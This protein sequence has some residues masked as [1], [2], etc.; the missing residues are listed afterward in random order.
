M[1]FRHLILA[2]A[3]CGC[4]TAC[5]PKPPAPD[6]TPISTP[7]STPVVTDSPTM[8]VTISP[9]K[10]TYRVPTGEL[11]TFYAVTSNGKSQEFTSTE[12]VYTSDEY[13][14]NVDQKALPA[15]TGNDFRTMP[16]N[17]YALRTFLLGE[18]NIDIINTNI[19]SSDEAVFEIKEVIDEYEYAGRMGVSLINR[20]QLFVYKVLWDPQALSEDSQHQLAK[21]VSD[22]FNRRVFEAGSTDTTVENPNEGISRVYIPLANT[23]YDIVVPGSAYI[24]NIDG[25]KNQYDIWYGK[26]IAASIQ[27]F[28]TSQ[29]DLSITEHNLSLVDYQKALIPTSGNYENFKITTAPTAFV[30]VDNGFSNKVSYVWGGEAKTYVDLY[31]FA[32]NAGFTVITVKSFE[33]IP[34]SFTTDYMKFILDSDRK[35]NGELNTIPQAL[36]ST[37]VPQD[38]V[39]PLH[40]ESSAFKHLRSVSEDF[41]ES[42]FGETN[43]SGAFM[44]KQLYYKDI[45]QNVLLPFTASMDA[46]EGSVESASSAWVPFNGELEDAKQV[47]ITYNLF[48]AD[49]TSTEKKEGKVPTDS[50]T[51]GF[52]EAVK[53]IAG[54]FFLEMEEN[55]VYP[56]PDS[57]NVNAS[58]YQRQ[59]SY[60]CN[61]T[62][63]NKSYT[64]N[65]AIFIKN[66]GDDKYQDKSRNY[67]SA[68]MVWGSRAPSDQV[69]NFQQAFES[70]VK[71]VQ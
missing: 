66:M 65:V 6:S 57:E 17:A 40:L 55:N 46:A 19:V 58:V 13:T 41:M 35:T 68:V 44:V 52:F 54:E 31:I 60:R 61:D 1:R 23:D 39:Y 63:T 11:G 62:I 47:S 12:N 16:D 34:G 15:G 20:T 69:S 50:D 43:V 25:T 14:L 3:L 36:L 48:S 5:G 22:T 53:T 4:L 51:Y 64:K 45:F 26:T 38:A 10:C 56:S 30:D 37:A 71:Q 49:P 27:R 21:M 2:V 24:R 42:N 29:V 70:V 18:Y 32:D 9:V 67:F 7:E 33:P 59:F 8:D 28:D